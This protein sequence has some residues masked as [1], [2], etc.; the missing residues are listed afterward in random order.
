MA[1]TVTSNLTDISMCEST[2]G[3]VNLGGGTHGINDPTVFDAKEGTYC[4]QDY[5]ASASNRGAEYDLGG[6][7]DFSDVIVIFWFAFSKVYHATNPMRIRITDGD[8]D[9][10]EWNIFT[11]S[12]LPHTGWIPWALKPSVTPDFESG[13]FDITIAR[14]VGWIVDGVLAKTYIYWDAVRYGY[15]LNIKGGTSGDPATFEDFITAESTY[16]YGILEKYNGVYFAQGQFNIGSLTVDE[17]TYFKDNNKVLIFKDIKGTPSGF[18]EIKGQNATSGSGETKIF[19]GEKSGTV[20]IAGCFIRASPE[21]KFKFTM[22]DTYIT[23]FGFYGCTFV[24]ADTIQGQAYSTLKEFLSSTF[25]TCA[26][27]LPDTGIVDKC[28]YI[29]AIDRAVRITDLTNHH[30]TNSNFISCG[31]AIHVNV[32]GN[33]DFD[34]L[35]FSGNT[36]DVEFSVAGTLNISKLNGSNPSTE[37]SPLGDVNFLLSVT[38]KVIVKDEG[39]SPIENAQVGIFRQSNMEQLMNEDTLATGIAEQTFDYGAGPDV[40][41]YLRIR[42]SSTGTRYYPISTIGTITTDGFTY[43]AVLIED[44]I[45]I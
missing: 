8:G 27:M 35:M 1:G 26:E 38:L 22:V 13:T 15:G 30:I 39:G 5:K 7:Q 25:I 9:Y 12:T 33:V 18:Y 31:H 37:D 23:E 34:A 36:K 6:N 19:L 10:A 24:N 29:S 17:S 32:A 40:D 14:K 2:D 11:K 3:W 45:A 41:V 42:K 16:A 28:Y 44:E 43:Y 4:L 20:G 21:M